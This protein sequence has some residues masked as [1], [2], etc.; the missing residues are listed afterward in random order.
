[1]QRGARVVARILIVREFRRRRP[2]RR[3]RTLILPIRVNIESCLELI[4][5]KDMTLRSGAEVFSVPWELAPQIL[6][7]A[8]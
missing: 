8:P 2:S 6:L 3:V 5:T 7:G 4:V 1:M